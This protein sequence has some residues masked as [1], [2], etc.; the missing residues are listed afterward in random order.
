MFWRR[1]RTTGWTSSRSSGALYA[2]SWHCRPDLIAA[3]ESCIEVSAMCRSSHNKYLKLGPSCWSCVRL[4]RGHS[5]AE[6][7]LGPTHHFAPPGTHDSG[8]HFGGALPPVAPI[9]RPASFGGRLLAAGFGCSMYLAFTAHLSSASLALCFSCVCL[10]TSAAC[11]CIVG[12]SHLVFL[13]H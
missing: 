8:C 6:Q 5:S 2:A 13:N 4:T 12:G 7:H 3:R 1:N 11:S 9:V 10:A